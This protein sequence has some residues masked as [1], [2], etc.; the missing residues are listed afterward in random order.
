LY[1]DVVEALRCIDQ[2][3]DGEVCLGYLYISL[4]FDV[5]TLAD[6]ANM[7]SRAESVTP[8]EFRNGMPMAGNNTGL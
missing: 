8:R 1:R 2:P 6:D 4:V 3:K 7:V 5:L